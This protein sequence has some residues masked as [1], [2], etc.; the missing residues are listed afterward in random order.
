MGFN[1]A[2]LTDFVRNNKTA[3]IVTIVVIA[4]AIVVIVVIV[5][6]VKKGEQP[7]TA[8]TFVEGYVGT[9][10]YTDQFKYAESYINSVLGV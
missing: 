8:E 2:D 5:I 9:D 1:L 6:L 4:I 3:I 7:K 10:A